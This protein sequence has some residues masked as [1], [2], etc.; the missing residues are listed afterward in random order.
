VLAVDAGARLCMERTWRKC[1]CDT[2]A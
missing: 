1:W 2:C